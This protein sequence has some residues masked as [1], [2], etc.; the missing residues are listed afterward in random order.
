M[1]P[2]REIIRCHSSFEEKVEGDWRQYLKPFSMAMPILGKEI[3]VNSVAVERQVPPK[4]VNED[5]YA[6]LQ[7]LKDRY[8]HEKFEAARS[9]TNPFENIGKKIFQNRAAIK[10]ANI[11]AVFNLTESTG[12]FINKR[13]PEPFIFADVAGGPGGFTEYLQYRKFNST[14]FGITLSEKSGGIPWNL[15]HIQTDY[16]RIN[17]GSD[18]TGNLYVSANYF[19][20]WVLASAKGGVH[21]VVADGGIENDDYRGQELKSSHLILTEILVALRIVAVG[22]NLVLKIFDSISQ[23][24]IDLLFVL[25]CCFEEI[26]IFKPISS[27]PANTERY[28]IAK[29]RRQ[30]ISPYIDLL[31]E[32]NAKYKLDNDVDIVSQLFPHRTPEFDQ[33]IYETN[34]ISLQLQTEVAH[35]IIDYLENKKPILPKYNLPR[36]LIIWNLPSR[37]TQK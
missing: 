7:K 15:D 28:V 21:L 1:D 29:T 24:T 4:L 5:E 8:Q 10:L 11:D 20:D 18:G 17:H 27:R 14:G 32:A 37:P 13:S 16:F 33:F 36:A 31:Q 30:N 6:N 34:Q 9:A 19:A 3:R 12:G 2:S 25:A 23:I 26:H 35:N 22:K